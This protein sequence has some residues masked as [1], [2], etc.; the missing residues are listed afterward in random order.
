MHWFHAL[1]EGRESFDSVEEERAYRAKQ[2]SLTAIEARELFSL[3]DL[4]GGE[5]VL[6]LFCGNGRHSIGM[7][8]LGVR[9]VGVDL[10]RSRVRFAHRWAQEAGARAHFLLGDVTSPPLR[11]SASAILILG[12]SFSHCGLWDKDVELLAALR[13]LLE[14]R[15]RLLIDNPNPVR[16]WSLRNPDGEL[17]DPQA[18]PCFDLPLAGDSDQCKVRYWGAQAMRR[19]FQEAGYISVSILGD[20]RGGPYSAHSPRLVAIAQAPEES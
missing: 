16:F 5:L 14:P 10:A 17:P 11:G 20:R 1:Y 13:K 12:G 19:L 8:S 18:L 6:D 3:L 7:A 2:S 4:R 15:G 9:V